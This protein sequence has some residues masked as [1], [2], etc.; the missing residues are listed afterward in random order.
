M[1]LNKILVVQYIEAWRRIICE[2][3]SDVYHIFNVSGRKEAINVLENNDINVIITGLEIASSNDKHRSTSQGISFIKWVRSNK[4]H[5][6]IV[7][8][9]GYV[10]HPKQLEQFYELGVQDI[11][12]KTSSFSYEN[13][14]NVIEKYLEEDKIKPKYLIN[15]LSI[16]IKIDGKWSATDFIILLVALRNIYTFFMITS[17]NEF[18]KKHKNEDIWKFIENGYYEARNNPLEVSKIQYASPGSISLKGLGEPIKALKELFEGIALITIKWKKEK[19]EVALKKHELK[20]KELDLIKKQQENSIVLKKM[21][22]DYM[23]DLENKHIDTIERRIEILKKA[24]IEDEEIKRLTEPLYEN[25]YS[26]MYLISDDKIHT[27][28]LEE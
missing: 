25:I 8:L 12:F 28:E 1:S 2:M 18:E 5:I 7:V 17:Y 13:L 9:T 22:S 6:P 20:E 14:L 21:E 24:G 15:E 3:L 4:P 16:K 11:I 10:I 26:I 23:F 27:P 19:A